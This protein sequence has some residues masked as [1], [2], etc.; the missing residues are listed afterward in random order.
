[1]KFSRT[2]SAPGEPYAGL[3]FE[4]R[5]SRIVN[6]DGSVIFE[7]KDVM[8]PT[9]WS[10]VA[11]DVLAQKY[12]RKAGVPTQLRQ[13]PEDGVPEW[14][15]RSEPADESQFGAERD[16]RQVFNRLAGCWTY[17]A[18]KH[19]YFDSE[20][21]ARVYYDEMSA[22]L[23][24]QIGAPNSPQW[25]NT[26][27]H[28]A[29]GI[30][31]PAQGHF[32]V[33]P[34]TH[35]LTRSVNAYEHPAPHACL[36]YRAPVETP[37]GPIPIGEIVR[38]SLIGLPVYDMTGETRVAAVK[39]NGVKAVYRVRLA[40]GSCIEA[41]ADHVVLARRSNDE[42][43]SWRTVADLSPE[44]KLVQRHDFRSR[45]LEQN[46]VLR[47]QLV[48]HSV[49][50]IEPAPKTAIAG[51]ID[52]A[53]ACV[54]YV[55]HEEVY[56]IETESHNFL[57]NSIVVH[58]CF[59]QSVE[60][61]L[62][63]E[64]GIMDLWVR[65]A[66]I[67][68]FGSGTGSNFSQLRG[69]GE[70]LSGGGTSSG[71]MSFLRVGD[72]AAGA[73]KSGG[74]TR[75]AAKMVCLDLDHPDVEKFINWKVTE[76]QK[77]SD[78]VAGSIVCEKHLNAIMRAAWDDG[79]PEDARLDP[80]LNPELR[81]AMRAAI[82][83]GIPQAN[84][85]YA[86]DFAKQGYKHLEIETYDTNWD[87]KA[88]GT[89]S[90]QNSNNSIR[91]PN[92]FFE[93]LDKGEDF[94]LIRRTD[95]RVHKSV[96]AADLWEHIAISAWQCADPGTQYDTT[97]NEWHT[98]P[99]D[100][101]INASNPCVTAD[102]LV[103]T[104]DGLKPVRE[105][106]GTPFSAAVDGELYPSAHRGFFST[107]EKPVLRLVAGNGDTLLRVTANH[108]IRVVLDDGSE[109]WRIVSDL[110][111][112]DRLALHHADGLESP[113]VCVLR[114]RERG[115]VRSL[116][117]PSVVGQASAGASLRTREYVVLEDICEDGVEAVYDCT[118]PGIHAFDANGL[119][120]HNCS[121]YMFLDDT[122]CNLA[123]MNLVTFE[124]DNGDFDVKRFADACRIWTF[125]L[126]VSV[127]MAQF[128]SRI[129]AQKSYDF[130]T[131]GL[132]YANLG[133]LLMRMGLPYDSEE[134]FGWCAAIT[135]LMTGAAYRCSAE[136]AQQLGA[137]P[138]YEH[139]APEMLR[140]IRNHRRAAYQ[141]SSDQYEGLSV[142][143]ITH[144][145]SLFTQETW[146]AARKMWD[147]ALSI[148]EVAGYRNAQVTVIAPTGC[149]T[150]NSLVATNHGLMRLNR[151]GNPD[152]EKWQ[153]VN[154]R[155]LTDDGE[156]QAT[157]FYI[158]GVEATRRI[159]TQSGYAIQGTL[160][161]RVKVVDRVTGDL[162]WKRLADIRE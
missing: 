74:T 103:A 94:N 2:Y 104:A 26:G 71:L 81:K 155:V 143:P 41:T 80:A 25:F 149:L 122:A 55:A 116:Q 111:A 96:P 19:G 63:N 12:C 10:Q 5:T 64:G 120:V 60:D 46:V 57:T 49:R 119:Y 75:R 79:L 130:R 30:A 53:V 115:L 106:V 84:V 83:A 132:G 33:D 17:W 93:K 48:E 153:D 73:I 29:Y 15:W 154:L 151:L 105:L 98:C 101:R 139:N 162:Q 43:Y 38:R 82:N 70:K 118:V 126:E 44:W 147:D 8:V 150:G 68:K 56:D 52:V 28:W 160:G 32:F 69:E 27:L 108:P 142:K 36:P 157:K 107:G 124:N 54:E 35:E 158:N 110:R 22:M 24:R 51:T 99:S 113:H 9:G 138:R 47:E 145:P 117:V 66:R 50:T 100:G 144:A 13:I 39:H 95:G 90:G 21:D 59:I 102:T 92:S 40:G 11:V 141:A 125:T 114:L 137:F 127:L 16:A 159:V 152:G 45:S 4:P 3:T 140:V 78:L 129:I 161:H 37:D 86:L 58:N 88:Y 136:M 85:Q 62:V 148:G 134:A 121:E 18:H 109:E 91:I 146:A 6:P 23:A 31:G 67:F 1:M 72:R 123:S 76:E 135:A 128:P 20:E 65:E 87:S 97:I 133:T 112:G 34:Q 7:A 61:D 42:K 14:L 77:V 89:V 156:Q 131:L